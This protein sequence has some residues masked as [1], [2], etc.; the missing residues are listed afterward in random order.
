MWES[1]LNKLALKDKCFWINAKIN[2][3]KGFST[4]CVSN[5]AFLVRE[6]FPKLGFF[7]DF[8]YISLV[9]P[10]FIEMVG[11]ARSALFFVA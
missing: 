3:R 5:A 9:S 6:F 8:L 4:L 10:E 2:I 7:A 11:G 1:N